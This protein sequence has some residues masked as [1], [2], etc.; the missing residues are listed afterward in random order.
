MKIKDIVAVLGLMLI[1]LSVSAQVV[2]KDSINMLKDQKQVIE[3]SK[4]LNER[5]L[6]LAKL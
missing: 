6:E 3:V 1:S 5:K 4:R 2:S